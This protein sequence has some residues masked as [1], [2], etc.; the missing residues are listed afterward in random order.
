MVVAVAGIAGGDGLVVEGTSINEVVRS[1][2]LRGRGERR[3]AEI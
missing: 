2:E 1:Q 3:D